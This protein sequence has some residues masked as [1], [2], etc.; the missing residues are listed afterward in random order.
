MIEKRTA[1]GAIL[2]ASVEDRGVDI[3]TRHSQNQLPA[4][5]LEPVAEAL[6][7]F[8]HRKCKVRMLPQEAVVRMGG[9]KSLRSS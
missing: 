2:E 3:S 6:N 4:L 5:P 8:P 7:Q 9:D 1:M